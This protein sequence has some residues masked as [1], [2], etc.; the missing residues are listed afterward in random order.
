MD[1]LRLG[2]KFPRRAL[3]IYK[4]ALSVGLMKPNTI[5]A[6]LTL[7][8]YF[9][10]TRLNSNTNNFIT[11]GL[12]KLQVECGQNKSIEDIPSKEKH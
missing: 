5:L 3:Y 11:V 10:H 2:S 4:K 9:G 6:I 1:K 7:K 8:L 12:Q